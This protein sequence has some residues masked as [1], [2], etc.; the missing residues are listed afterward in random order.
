MGSAAVEVYDAAADRWIE[1]PPMPRNNW[2]QVAAAIDG[3]IYVLGGGNYV[4]SYHAKN[5]VWSSSDGVHWTCETA[6]APWAPRLWFSAAVYRGRMRV[7]GG[8]SKEKDNHG[9]VWH[10]TDGKNWQRLETNTCWK[11]R[12]E[13]SALVFQEKLWVL[14]GHARPLSSEVWSL[15]LPADWKP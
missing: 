4:P 3:K 13:H 14:G 8:W 2:E 7:L 10:S 5:D 12:H 1:K 6:S 9:D 11:S 15:S